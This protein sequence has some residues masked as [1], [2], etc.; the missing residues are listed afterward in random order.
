V[1]LP[2]AHVEGDHVLGAAGEQAVGEAPGRGAHVQAAA[3]GGVDPEGVERV[4][5]LHPRARRVRG[6]L[7]Q[8][9][10]DVLRDELAGL[11]GGLGDGAEP[12]VARHDG[13]RGARA[14]LEVAALDEQ[15]VEADPA[16]RGKRIRDRVD[17][18][19]PWPRSALTTRR[20]GSP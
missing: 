4:L 13:R 14:T 11:A 6:S 7:A 15:S 17:A 12:D 10:P 19:R 20:G 18:P 9:H 2:V 8:R 5:E 3:P 1:K 16:H